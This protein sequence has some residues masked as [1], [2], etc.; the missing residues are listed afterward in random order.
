MVVGRTT[1]LSLKLTFSRYQ[2]PCCVFL[3]CCQSVLLVIP[4]SWWCNGVGLSPT[5]RNAL[6]PSQPPELTTISLQILTNLADQLCGVMHR[7]WECLFLSLRSFFFF[8]GLFCSFLR[9][10]S[11]FPKERNDP[12]L[13]TRPQ[14][15]TSLMFWSLLYLKPV[16]CESHPFPLCHDREECW[17]VGTDKE[18][19]GSRCSPLKPDEICWWITG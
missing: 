7:K 2:K 10:L 14:P 12:P 6:A 19:W 16:K 9:D 11:R 1:G 18:A 13:V 4:Q 15:S 8:F 17:Y 3:S 5:A